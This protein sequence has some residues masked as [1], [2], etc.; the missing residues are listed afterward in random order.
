M[1]ELKIDAVKVAQDKPKKDKKPKE[2]NPL[3]YVTIP[4]K[5]YKRLLIAKEDV[6]RKYKAK[7]KKQTAQI[8]SD[9]NMYERWYREKRDKLEEAQKVIAGYKEMAMQDLGLKDGGSD[10]E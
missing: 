5:E 2:I 8:E 3:D 9:R 4:I 7:L 10:A 1:E 6:K